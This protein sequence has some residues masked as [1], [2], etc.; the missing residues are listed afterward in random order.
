MAESGLSRP[1]RWGKDGRGGTTIASKALDGLNDRPSASDCFAK[2]LPSGFKALLRGQDLQN[3]GLSAL[4]FETSFQGDQFGSGSLVCPRDRQHAID[5]RLV[6]A[7][8]HPKNLKKPRVKCAASSFVPAA[9]GRSA[10]G[11]HQ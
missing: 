2:S 7:L 5:D 1:S 8:P 4:G 11:Q 3:A 9:N 6:H 10:P